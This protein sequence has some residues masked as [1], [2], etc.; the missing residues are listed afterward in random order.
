MLA[1]RIVLRPY[2]KIRDV[3]FG[4]MIAFFLGHGAWLIG[5]CG[6][7]LHLSSPSLVPLVPLLVA[8]PTATVM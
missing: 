8:H 2:P 1:V 6:I 7:V 5:R 3:A 4:T